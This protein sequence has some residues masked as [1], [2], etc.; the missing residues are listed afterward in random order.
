MTHIFNHYNSVY[1]AFISQFVFHRQR[2]QEFCKFINPDI[3]NAIEN[4]Q[5]VS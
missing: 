1:P 4:T 5:I 2:I 3:T